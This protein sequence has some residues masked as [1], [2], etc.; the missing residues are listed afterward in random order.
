MENKNNESGKIIIVGDLFPV[1]SNFD[2]FSKG[3]IQTLFG[4]EICDLF[5]SADYRICNLEGALTDGTERCEKT[6]PAY[7]APT[8][9]IKAVK[10]IGIDCCTL[11]NNHITDAGHSGVLDTM[12]TLNDCGIQHLGAGENSNAIRKFHSFE[13]G[14]HKIGL[15]NVAETM[16]NAP[17][18]TQSGAN[19]Y[20]EYLVCKEIESLKDACDCLIV[21]YHGGIEKFR[22]PS[23]EIKKRFHRMAD[24]GAD[25]V[26][27]QHTHCV[28]CEEY[29]KGSYLLYGQGNFLFK[30]FVEGLTDS[31]L[32]LE[33]F[34][35]NDNFK[36]KKHIVNAVDNFLEYAPQQDFSQFDHR[37]SMLGDDK[38]LIEQFQKFSYSELKRYFVAFKGKDYYRKIASRLFPSQFKKS[39]LLKAYSREQLLFT[40]HTLRS[41]Q[42]RETAIEGIKNLLAIMEGNK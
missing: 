8:S 11:A 30:S 42:N 38:F 18:E 33:I 40:L 41:E 6:G 12:R 9:T 10:E 37:S 36:V 3:D 13:V 35:E 17:T 1:P 7:I 4:K 39:Y 2:L 24:C 25:M 31:G 29:Y 27:S 21:I 34:F 19:L 28:G 22:Y 26:L 16:Y 15:Y 32:I 23:P 20:D 14:N 5:A